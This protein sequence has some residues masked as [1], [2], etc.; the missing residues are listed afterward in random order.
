MIGIAILSII[1]FIIASWL[2]PGNPERSYII[3][4]VTLAVLA[5]I[6]RILVPDD[7]EPSDQ[8]E[9]PPEL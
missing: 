1:G 6:F 9:I 3:A 5:V 7:D 2:S 4:A 8:I